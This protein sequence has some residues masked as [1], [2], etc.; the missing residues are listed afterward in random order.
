M[1]LAWGM[2]LRG[3][4]QVIGR[5]GGGGMGTVWHGRDLARNRDVAIKV[6]CHRLSIDPDFV[7][8]PP[9]PQGGKPWFAWVGLAGLFAAVVTYGI[10]VVTA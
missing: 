8:C 1:A 2:I 4:Y 7:P 6:L 3:R 5:L 9:T 10:L